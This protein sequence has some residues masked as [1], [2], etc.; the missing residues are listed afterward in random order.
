MLESVW[1]FIGGYDPK[2]QKLS[3]TLVQISRKFAE[4]PNFVWKI[5]KNWSNDDQFTTR[6]HFRWWLKKRLLINTNFFL[7]YHLLVS[8]RSN[9]IKFKNVKSPREHFFKE[10]RGK[11]ENL[12]F[13]L[14]NC[15][16]FIKSKCNIYLSNFYLFCF[17]LSIFLL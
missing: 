16:I 8:N 17:N 9:M 4:N 13:L 3:W 11:Y 14:K 1:S 12:F 5:R 2:T 6:L 10:K 7:V 15:K